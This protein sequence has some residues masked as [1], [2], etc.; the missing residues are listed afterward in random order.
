MPAVS[1][2]KARNRIVEL[3]SDTVYQALALKESL[4]DERK[5]LETEDM[6]AIERAVEIKSACVEKLKD[7][8][9]K[10][11]T[12]C[13]SWGFTAGPDQMQDVIDYCDDAD[14]IKD[15]W[16][17]LMVIAAESSAINLTNGAII[18]IRQQQFESSLSLLRG[19]TP[20]IDTYGQHGNGSGD[21]KSQSLAQ[22]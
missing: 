8:D 13:K 7:L 18:R 15:R 9:Q 4:E 3:L 20:R 5:A 2:D 1:P 6:A 16:N 14:L 10:R 17:E 19:R 22:A 21:F 12:L 11:D